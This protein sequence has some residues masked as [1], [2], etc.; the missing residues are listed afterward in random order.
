MDNRRDEISMKIDTL[1]HLDA[2]TQNTNGFGVV[3]SPLLELLDVPSP[4]P[5]PR[6]HRRENGISGLGGTGSI[7]ATQATSV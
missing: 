4:E 3:V 7:S 2:T 6:H 5:Q 1:W